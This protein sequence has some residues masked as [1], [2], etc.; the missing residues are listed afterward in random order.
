MDKKLFGAR[1][2][3]YLKFDGE[4][5]ELAKVLAEKMEIPE[6]YFDTHEEP[7]HDVFGLSEFAGFELWLNKSTDI[8]GFNFEIEIETSMAHRDR[9]DNVMFDLSPWF[10][11]EIS[12][13]YEI[14]TYVNNS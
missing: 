12:R 11:K 14:E 7:P 1:A 8:E 4:M 9:M 2:L 6:I 3:V 13:R 10:A 5:E